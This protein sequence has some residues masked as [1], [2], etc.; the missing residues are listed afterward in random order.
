MSEYIGAE[1]I[2]ELTNEELEKIYSSKGYDF[3]LS[4]GGVEGGGL[5]PPI[6]FRETSISAS[7]RSLAL[8]TLLWR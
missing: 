7:I 8:K 3:P 1:E 5:A 4:G 2:A 6:F